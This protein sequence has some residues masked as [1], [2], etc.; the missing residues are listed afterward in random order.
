MI[1]LRSP[2]RSFS[3]TARTHAHWGMI[4]SILV[5]FL[6]VGSSIFT[7]P[8]T[9]AFAASRSHAPLKLENGLI[10]VSSNLLLDGQP[11]SPDSYESD[12]DSA[13]PPPPGPPNNPSPGTTHSIS[14]LAKPISTN[15]TIQS[16]N[17]TNPPF[18]LDWVKFDATANDTY[19]IRTQ[20]TNDINESD[21]YANDT[22]LYLYDSTGTLL[23]FNDDVGWTTWYLGYYY[24]RESVIDWT[25]PASATYY[26]LETQW[27]PGAGNGIRDCH[28]YNLWVLDLTNATITTFDSPAFATV[29]TAVTAGDS[30]T[31]V[32]YNMSNP[33]TGSVTFTL[34]SDAACTT[35]V[36]GM[37][38][39]GTIAGNSASWS[40]NW[41][42]SSVSSIN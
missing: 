41:T 29:G 19:E 26:V 33:P 28:T 35:P 7:F 31:F 15:G 34:Y 2:L 20:L 23:A 42:P 11:C 27:G 40:A 12:D 39:S 21:T 25:A 6:L 13:P 22:L 38:G 16:H 18:E 10:S 8:R 32:H 5:L 1:N 14:S 3:K 24:Y 36:S 9:T 30:A 17:N 4:R 37:S